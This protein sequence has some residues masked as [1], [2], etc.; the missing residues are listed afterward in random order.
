MQY[1]YFARV[2]VE[3]DLADDLHKE[4]LVE[5]DGYA[6]LVPVSYER[7]PSFCKHCRVIGHALGE[8]KRRTESIANTA[9][10]AE[11]KKQKHVPKSKSDTNANL[12]P[13]ADNAVTGKVV[14]QDTNI[15]DLHG[16]SSADK[17]IQDVVPRGTTS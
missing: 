6:F 3:N 2:L 4:I 12:G 15:N 8:C 13:A 16:T 10:A 5:R 9:K 17:E 7:L 14:N 1:G 11:P